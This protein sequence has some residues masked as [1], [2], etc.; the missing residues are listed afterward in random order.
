MQLDETT[1][2]SAVSLLIRSMN[3]D[4]LDPLLKEIEALAFSGLEVLVV[5][6]SGQTHAPLP[7]VGYSLRLIEP[8]PFAPLPRARAANTALDAVTTPLAMFLDDDDGIDA[9]HLPSLI[10][11]LEANPQAVAAYTGV[12]LVDESGRTTVRHE[13]WYEG[14]LWLVNFLPIH[15]VLFRM[16]AVREG[17]CR[18]DSDFDQ[19]EDWDFWLQLASH[20]GDFACCPG[21][22]ATYRLDRGAS[23]LSRQ[24][25]RQHYGQAR[26]AIY[27]KWLSH[28][29]N[30]ALGRAV[31]HWVDTFEQARWDNEQ[32]REQERA[33]FGSA[34]R[35]LGALQ[36]LREHY[37]ALQAVH[38]Q[39]EERHEALWTRYH[40]LGEVSEQHRGALEE[41]RTHYQALQHLKGELDE[42]HSALWARYHAQG[43]QAERHR[44][45]LEALQTHHRSL[46]QLESDLGEARQHSDALQQENTMLHRHS[47]G[48]HQQRD[49]LA[50][51]RD[52]L[53]Q[54]LHLLVG[55]RSWRLTGPLRRAVRGARHL[56]HRNAQKTDKGVSRQPPVRRFRPQGAVD[57]IVPVY[58]GLDETRDCL[59]SVW[60]CRNETSMRLVVV[61]DASPEPALTEWLREVA[62]ADDPERPITLLENPDNLGFVGSVNRG[63]RANP[64]ADVV[65]LN[66]DAEVVNDW[67]DRLVGAAYRPAERP[68]ATVTPF[69]N[70][71][72]I[73]SYPKF[74][75]D[76]EL[77]PGLSIAEIDALFARANSQQ[78][79]DIPTGIGFCLYIRRDSLDD[80]GLFDEASFGKG[81]GE[82]NDFCMRSLKAGWRHAHA[83]D[84]FAWHKGSV[85]FGDTQPERVTH[86]LQVLHEL[87]PDYESR[88]HHFIQRDP[89]RLARQRVDLLRLRESPRPR[90]MLVNHQRGGGTEQHCRELA[91]LLNERIDFLMLRPGPD[92]LTRLEYYPER[93]SLALEYRLP[94]DFDALAALLS[95]IGISRI[96]F[97]HWLGLDGSVM[98]L[99]ARLGVPQWVTLH[100]YYA[101][102]P[103][104]TLTGIDNRYCGEE[105]LEQCKRCLKQAPATG[106]VP[107]ETWRSEHQRWLGECERVI[108]PSEDAARRIESYFQGLSVSAVPHPEVEV[109]TEPYPLPSNSDMPE[110]E[111]LRVAIIGAISVIKGADEI[112]AVAREAQKRGLAI[113]F[114][115]FGYA[116]RTLASLSTLHVTGPYDHRALPGMLQTWQPHAVWFPARWPE[117]WSYTLSTCMT[118]GLPVVATDLGAIA[119]RI[120]GRPLSWRLPLDTSTAQWCDWFET[121]GVRL[122]QE[123]PQEDR[124]QRPDRSDFYRKHYSALA[125]PEALAELP[126]DWATHAQSAPDTDIRARMKAINTLYWLRRQPWLQGVARRVPLPWQR[127]VKSWLLRER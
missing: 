96:H 94:D 38:Q 67:L 33:H 83:L 58:R 56:R 69:S 30:A 89:A 52:A 53:E 121:L 85:S 45:E 34:E 77:P 70:N 127:R 54:D 62:A 31:A 97:H 60:A 68:V 105:G 113:E 91:T 27:K 51:E 114:R 10:A 116:Y 87:H 42:Q 15:A 57:V 22:S 14:A 107:I 86:A 36:E 50:R 7:V 41:L 43:E 55:S 82:E 104:I 124:W 23:G 72:T 109:I 122:Q 76:N 84:V 16:E 102:C 99:A 29:D 103:Q 126:G 12:R 32:L 71:A 61:N 6:A 65:L 75:E 25:D 17:G 49:R 46:Q 64:D 39:L 95:A 4:T 88:V 44:V 100:D 18:F 2:A 108:A 74:C 24:R 90:V 20:G 80:V 118:L 112:E 21:V 81:Y 73:C 117:T 35:H 120:E 79:V 47:A 3:R 37:Q 28:L 11:C 98:H 40:A 5:N 26:L 48:L 78:S 110:D 59:E 106:G 19:L 63:M 13:P 8:A 125:L 123:A 111:P 66:S 92:G 9:D 1:P 101:A 119:S 115:L 93:E